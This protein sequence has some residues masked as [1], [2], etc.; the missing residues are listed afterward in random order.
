MRMSEMMSAQ[1]K[2]DTRSGKFITL[3]TE[4]FYRNLF[5]EIITC[6]LG[7]RVAFSYSLLTL[8][9]FFCRSR[10]NWFC[11]EKKMRCME[12]LKSTRKNLGKRLL[13]TER[14]K[15]IRKKNLQSCWEYPIKLSANGKQ[16]FPKQKDIKK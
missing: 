11:N 1:S 12:C 16:E 7:E 15:D 10:I 8:D 14:R 6:N 2:Y 13:S 9:C 3:K 4:G 5:L